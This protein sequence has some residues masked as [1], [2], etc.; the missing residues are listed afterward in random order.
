VR[1]A[2]A[3][4]QFPRRQRFDRLELSR[5]LP[6]GRSLV[7]GFVL[8]ALAGGL[9]AVARTTPAFAV[10]TVAVEGVSPHVAAEVREAVAPAVGESLLAIDL[11]QLGDGVR[12]VP[13]VASVR[14]DRTF[15]HTLRIAVLPQ[16]PVAV[17]RQGA[18]SWVVAAGGRVLAELDRGAR[19]DLP[20]IWLTRAVDVEVGQRIRGLP[21]RALAAVTPL[22]E[23][24]LPYRVTTAVAT[25]TEVLLKLRS[26]LE[27][28]LGGSTDLLLKLD[29]ARAILPSLA[30]EQGYLDVSVPER[31]VAGESLNS[32]VEVETQPSSQP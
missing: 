17:L 30:G 25:P 19:K 12:R 16:V 26:G 24:P 2:T 27:L 14:F 31:P 13:M 21:V 3:A 5:M 8:V 29:V 15:P 18:A 11:G 9:Y 1:A 10:R 7:V 6:S 23:R 4:V 32:Q 28:R 20:R 22:V